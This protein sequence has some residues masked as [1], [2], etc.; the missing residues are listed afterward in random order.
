MPTPTKEQIKII[1]NVVKNYLLQ[2]GN[3]FSWKW[4]EV[5]LIVI[6]EWEKIRNSPK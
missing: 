4:E 5:V 1:L 6:T 3:I 2:S